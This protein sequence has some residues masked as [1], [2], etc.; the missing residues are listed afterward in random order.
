[1]QEQTPRRR[2]QPEYIAPS[3]AWAS[4]DGPISYGHYYPDDPY[5]E[6]IEI[7]DAKTTLTSSNAPF[8]AVTDGSLVIKAKCEDIKIKT[9]SETYHE[10]KSGEIRGISLTID[11]HPLS[12]H[13]DADEDCW[14]HACHG[15]LE[16]VLRRVATYTLSRLYAPDYEEIP[17]D[18]I[19]GFEMR[20]VTII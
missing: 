10:W 12:V 2:R 6:M 1:V 18:T 13:P 17:L 4:V 11:D 20:E 15:P 5:K 19:H 16:V 7:I 3:W 14:T 9:H 8:G